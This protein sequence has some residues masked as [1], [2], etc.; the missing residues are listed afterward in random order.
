[1][2]QQFCLQ[3]TV[4]ISSQQ[5]PTIPSPGK[6][7]CE[8]NTSQHFMRDLLKY[9]VQK[10]LLILRFFSTQRQGIEE[11]RWNERI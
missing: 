11:K 4:E 6:V 5:K 1:M 10:H 9:T 2:Q 8:N 3:K 7:K